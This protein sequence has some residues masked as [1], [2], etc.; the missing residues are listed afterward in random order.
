MHQFAQ[1]TH[2]SVDAVL[3]SSLNRS[4]PPLDEV[5]EA[6]AVELAELS[7]LEDGALWRVAREQ[8]SAADQDQMHRL[9]DR[10]A[11]GK[12]PQAEALQLQALLDQYSRVTVRKAHAYLLLARRGYRVPGGNGA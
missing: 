9:L 2:Q 11:E 8:L 3:E 12:L 5:P 7:L 6:E 10:Q 4:L 1:A